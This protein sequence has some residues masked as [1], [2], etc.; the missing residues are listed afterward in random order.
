MHLT[1]LV[2]RLA[3]AK[4]F[5]PLWSEEILREVEANL[6]KVDVDPTKAQRRVGRM[7]AMF[8]DALV[9][10]YQELMSEMTNDPKDSPGVRVRRDGPG[11]LRIRLW[12]P[13]QCGVSPSPTSCSSWT[14][15][16]GSGPW[17]PGRG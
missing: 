9:S 8:P 16:P 7:R 6:P 5:R 4:T 1:D 13:S 2:L 14:C 3:D 11:W 17:A 15:S 10:R 12:K